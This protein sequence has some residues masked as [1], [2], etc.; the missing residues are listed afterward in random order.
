MRKT[1]MKGQMYQEQWGA[2][3]TSD[4]SIKEDVSE[5]V[6][7]DLDLKGD[8]SNLVWMWGKNVPEQV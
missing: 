6:T 5:E 3:L 2:E 1:T 8:G 4:S 7:F